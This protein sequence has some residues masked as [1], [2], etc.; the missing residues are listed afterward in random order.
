MLCELSDRIGGSSSAQMY[1]DQYFAQGAH[2]DL[3][4]PEY[5]GKETL[6]MLKSLE[7]VDFNLDKKQWVFV[8]RD[9][10]ID[11]KRESKTFIDGKLRDDVLPKDASYAPFKALMLQFEGKMPMPTRLIEPEFHYLNS[12]SFKD[13]LEEKLTLTPE[14]L[15][16]IDYAMRDDWG[17]DASEISALA[18]VH[19]YTCRPY[20]SGH[21][22]LFSPPEGNAYFAQKMIASLDQTRIHVQSL[23]SN[24]QKTADG[25]VA[26]I[27]DVK[28]KETRTVRCKKVIYAAHKHALKFICPEQ[29]TAFKDNRYSPWLS[30]GIVLKSDGKTLKKYWQNEYISGAK[31]F[32]GFVDSGGQYQSRPMHRTL[33][34]YYCLQPK[35]RKQLLYMDEQAPKLVSQ[36][37][38][39]ME[40]VLKKP[41][42]ADIRK[43]FVKV[44]GHAMPIPAPGFLLRDVN[45]NCAETGFAFAGSDSGCL[46]LFFEC[47]DSGI[48]AARR[49]MELS[50]T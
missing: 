37:I 9:Y 16:A 23:V 22:E 44:M 1:K 13:F 50:S 42:R 17:S 34:A 43:V 10:V 24:I 12:I 18:G 21:V 29:A 20:F 38:Q 35:E 28:R 11:P 46:P 2:Y 26:Q 41:I 31:S 45:K 49:L 32:M 5:Y 19:Y 14:F 39:Y 3:A 30:M 15:Q 33:T 6:D 27:I 4:Y 48:M 7:I 40:E 8:D 36:T 25:Y 47:A